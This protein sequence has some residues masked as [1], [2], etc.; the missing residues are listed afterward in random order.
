MKKTLAT[1]LGGFSPGVSLV[2][3]PNTPCT[4]S[5][6][7]ASVDL[8]SFKL[9][10]EKRIHS[11]L[12]WGE[13]VP[14]SRESNQCFFFFFLMICLNKKQKQKQNPLPVNVFSPQH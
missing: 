13:S 5:T 9:G 10:L 11:L 4:V 8:L 2:L 14:T 12:F 6:G 1:K 7:T 3:V